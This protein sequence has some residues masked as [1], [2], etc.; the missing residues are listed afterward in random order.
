VPSWKWRERFRRHSGIRPE[1]ARTA[2]H[3]THGP[4]YWSGKAVK[5]GKES[6]EITT[7]FESGVI[8]QSLVNTLNGIRVLEKTG[9][10]VKEMNV[11]V[12]MAMASIKV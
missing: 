5:K 4:E 8:A 2:V 9:V 3:F 11:I 12:D 7:R 1:S 6:R 10:S